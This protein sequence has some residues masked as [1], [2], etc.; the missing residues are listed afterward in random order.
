M[1]YLNIEL[2]ATIIL[3]TPGRKFTNHTATVE[4]PGKA[5]KEAIQRLARAYAAWNHISI[6]IA[7]AGG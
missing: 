3:P 4:V 6:V 1:G 5:I 7:F 2:I